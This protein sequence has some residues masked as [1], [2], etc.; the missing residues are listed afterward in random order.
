[1][2]SDQQKVHFR[3]PRFIQLLCALSCACLFL[4]QTEKV[5]VSSVDYAAAETV[6]I[7][8]RYGLEIPIQVGDVQKPRLDSEFSGLFRKIKDLSPSNVKKYVEA[9]PTEYYALIRYIERLERENYILPDKASSLKK[10]STHGLAIRFAKRVQP[11]LPVLLFDGSENTSVISTT[12]VNDFADK[13]LRVE[14]PSEPSTPELDRALELFQAVMNGQDAEKLA[15]DEAKGEAREAIAQQTESAL[16]KIFK[17]A[18]V[19]IVGIDNSKPEFEVGF[20]ASLD[21]ME[22]ATT[23]QQTIV[24]AFDGR[25]TLNFGMGHRVMSQDRRWMTGLNAFYDHEFPDNHQRASL[26]LELISTPLSLT[27]NYYQGISGYK[28]DANG[29]EQ[30]PVDGFDAKLSAAL[31]YL[32]G[33]NASYET[34]KW[35][36]EDGVADLTRE[37]Y[38]LTGQLSKN[39]L[40][41]VEKAEFSD[42]RDDRESV[43]L[44]YQ[45]S[46]SDHEPP[47]IFDVSYQPWIF[48]SVESERYRFVDRENKILKQRESRKFIVRIGAS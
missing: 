9:R 32:P 3:R 41:A 14:K 16:S 33:V 21:E 35:F 47:T 5:A 38:G 31:P 8:S 46:P 26:G 18:K 15:I 13:E 44:S 40:I 42:N 4:F 27:G 11:R 6:Q 1:M 22:N 36:G 25:T 7:A 23:F 37:T 12:N 34:S 20:V 17:N 24:N 43:R 30:K 39:F 19:D 45:W 28:S 29:G 48:D 10:A 2:R